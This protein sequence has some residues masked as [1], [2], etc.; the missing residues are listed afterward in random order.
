MAESGKVPDH[1][2]YRII[3]SV[4]GDP[5]ITFSQLVERFAGKYGLSEIQSA[6]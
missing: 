4:P 3:A 1:Y 6:A 5:G 2:L